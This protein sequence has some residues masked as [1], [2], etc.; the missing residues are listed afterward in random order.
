MKCL[1][2]SN[3]SVVVNDLNES[4]RS[5]KAVSKSIGKSSIFFFFFGGSSVSGFHEWKLDGSFEFTLLLSGG[6]AEFKF[7]E[8]VIEDIEP[9]RVFVRDPPDGAIRMPFCKSDNNFC[10]TSCCLLCLSLI[11]ANVS[12]RTS[13]VVRFLLVDLGFLFC[14]S[15]FDITLIGPVVTTNKL[16][17]SCLL[18]GSKALNFILN[19]ISSSWLVKT[20]NL[21][22]MVASS[23]FSFIITLNSIGLCF[24]KSTSFSKKL[25][26]KT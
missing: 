4:I 11:L 26:N 25:I 17:I 10:S 8:L 20:F 23:P 5:L 14:L 16:H 21:H 24:T 3:R 18:T 13:F 9:V 7:N 1:I 2:L 15:G 22:S 19:N 12:N 6:R